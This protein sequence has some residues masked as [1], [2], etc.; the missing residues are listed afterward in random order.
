MKFLKAILPFLFFVVITQAENLSTEKYISLNGIWNFK[1]DYYNQGEAQKWMGIDFNDTGW[2]KMT[3]PGNWD[4]RN[5]Y[6]SFSGKGWYRTTFETPTEYRNKVIRLNFEAVGIDYKVWLNGELI[7]NVTGGYFPNFINISDNLKSGV[8]NTLVVS[9]D[10]T[11]HSGAYWSWG[12]IRRPVTLVI[13]NSLFIKSTHIIAIPDL[14]KGTATVSVTASLLNTAQLKAPVLLDYELSFTGKVIKK[15]SLNVKLTGADSQQSK[16][17]FNLASKDVKLW[18]FDF[19]NLYTIKIQL[20]HGNT[21]KHEIVERFGIRK[22]EIVGGK[23]MLNG[24]SVR[25]MGLNWVADDRLTGNTLP[26]DVYKRDIDN[27]KSMGVNLTRLSHVPLPKE[28]YDYLDEKGMMILAEIPV[29]GMTK[30]ADYSN[31]VP[32]SWLKQ[33]VNSNFNHPCIVGWCVGNE[34][35]YINQNKHV[36]GYV[37]KAVNYVKDSLDNSRLVVMVSHSASNQSDDPSKFGDFVPQNSYGGWGAD[38]D[39]IHKNQPNKAIFMTEFGENLIGEDLNTTTGNFAKMLNQIRWREYVFGASLWTYNDYRSFHRSSMLSWETKASENRDW[40]VVDGYGNKKRAFEILRKEQAPFKSLVVKQIPNALQISLK[41]RAKLDL[42]AYTLR[43]FSVVCEDFGSDSKLINKTQVLLPTINPGDSTLTKLIPVKGLVVA[44][45]ISVTTPTDY[46]Q[47]DTT[48]YYQ[49]PAKP[50]IKEVFN[51]GEKIRI[52]F[53][54][55]NFASTYKLMYGEKELTSTSKSTIDNYIEVADL[56]KNLLGKTYLLQL[57]ALNDFGEN[58]SEI[59]KEKILEHGVMPPVIKAIRAVQDGISIG[60]SSNKTEYLYK[61]QYSETS[62]FSFNTHI[63]QTTSKGA[64]F[65]PNLKSGVRYYVR[66]SAVEQYE[67]ISP[68]GETYSVIVN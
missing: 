43:G 48:I 34:I 52:V 57:V 27:M 60:Y 42:P 61:I 44:R 26:V 33:L 14:K 20:K 38:L 45:K 28:V 15:G 6:A 21:L 64:C 5:E 40:G 13:N 39:R 37:E 68:W 35:G 63:I 56:G 49:I 51:N 54:K 24:E 46:S 17:E 67:I 31:P 32:F 58:R 41:P 55:I 22:A 62:D 18:H 4:L 2:D 25:A 66:M 29:W 23:F 9:V 19:P 53:D 30:L 12:G 8:K 3:V 7:V 10:N 47:M 65:I 50:I 36:M 1:A 11:F 16:L 59:Y